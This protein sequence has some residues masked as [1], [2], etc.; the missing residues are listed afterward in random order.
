M[1]L[2]SI[3]IVMENIPQCGFD[4]ALGC[5]V[6]VYGGAVQIARVLRLETI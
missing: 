2:N 6:S 3:C 4:A 1:T 5:E